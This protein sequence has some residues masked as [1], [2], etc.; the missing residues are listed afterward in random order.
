MGLQHHPTPDFMPP[1]QMDVAARS[2]K[3]LLETFSEEPKVDE[4]LLKFVRQLEKDYEDHQDI[5]TFIFAIRCFLCWHR[6]VELLENPVT[7]A[8]IQKIWVDQNDTTYNKW[9]ASAND[10]QELLKWSKWTFQA[11]ISLL[12]DFCKKA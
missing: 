5:T 1:H 6:S 8:R 9:L 12:T 2:N 3:L 7:I 10:D 11:K 4:A